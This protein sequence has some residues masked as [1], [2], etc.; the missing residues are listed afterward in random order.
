MKHFVP[1]LLICVLLCACGHKQDNTA[2]LDSLAEVNTTEQLPE[3]I[4]IQNLYKTADSLMNIG[5]IDI[6][7]MQEYVNRALRY[8]QENPNDTLACKYIFFAGIFEMKIAS[9]TAEENLCN[10][11]YF[12]AINI[13]NSLI[14]NYPNFP[15]LD[16]C[17]WYKGTI[18]ENMKRTSDAENEYRELV[19]NFPK[20]DL[21]A[22][23]EAYLQSH[24][25][26]KDA[27]DLMNDI[28]KKTKN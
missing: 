12:N 23:T 4:Q 1:L 17:Y 19:H 10:D 27:N 2:I 20:S 3:N 13:F 28:K 16:Y 8:T 11:L 14:K 7:M 22:G 15:H 18:Y 24:G 26:E 21:A 6:E 5:Q 25:Y 9:S